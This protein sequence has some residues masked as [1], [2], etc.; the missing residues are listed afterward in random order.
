METGQFNAWREKAL[1]R[2]KEEADALA[3]GGDDPIILAKAGEKGI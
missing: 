1:E 2:L 3:A